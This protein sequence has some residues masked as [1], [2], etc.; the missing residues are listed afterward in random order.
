MPKKKKKSWDSIILRQQITIIVILAVSLSVLLYTVYNR[1]EN[2]IRKSNETVLR[3]KTEEVSM[4]LQNVWRNTYEIMSYLGERANV[5][6]NT[7]KMDFLLKADIYQL[8]QSNINQDECIDTLYIKDNEED[9]LILV[10]N[11]SRTYSERMQIQ[12]FV[13]ENDA[14]KH[15]TTA[16]TC[17]IVQVDGQ[18]YYSM[19]YQSGKYS[20]GA[21]SSLT[22][23][24]EKLLNDVAGTD[25]GYLMIQGDHLIYEGGYSYDS[26]LN[27]NG[28][29][30]STG[31]GDT[32]IA[33]SNLEL[34]DL[35]I[36]LI[37]KVNAI[38]KSIWSSDFMILF[39]LLTA[40]LAMDYFMRRSTIRMVSVPMGE[41]TEAYK[42]ISGG[43]INY[44]ITKETE[45]QEF[46]DFKQEFN[47]IAEEIS[48]LRI[49]EYEQKIEKQQTDLQVMRAQLRPHF[50][51][52]AITTVISMTYQ[53]RNDDIR[54]Y[55]MSL[56]K[57][58]RSMLQ[59]NLRM[60]PL[61]DELAN[62][63]DY[64]DMQKIRYPDMITTFISCDEK[65]GEV[66][67]PFLILFT[68]VENIFKHGRGGNE[69]TSVFIQCEPYEEEG[70]S[71]IRMISEDSGSG[72]SQEVLDR[73]RTGEN[74]RAMGEHIGLSN[75]YRTLQLT[76]QRT[77]LLRLSNTD[78][79][80]ARVE[81]L[82]PVKRDN[83]EN[84]DR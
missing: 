50:Y 10:I 52:N 69:E 4:M 68:A 66:E 31:N 67:V 7:G 58:M 23:Y 3:L 37:S 41:L 9:D 61:H 45:I 79:N 55:L 44:R 13:K 34:A 70:F 18:A 21:L 35:K 56:S 80:G 19:V 22:H 6:T 38:Q 62:I 51:L 53:N 72:F 25:V 81:I 73:Y 24:D 11:S 17:D 46:D 83:N 39:L 74:I 65:T 48:R 12:N 71:G 40:V 54:R 16:T 63:N 64:L 8:M 76:Y 33:S 57:F 15:N 49:E 77:D 26:L 82:I 60:V 2:E 42:Q 75:V 32:V 59:M 28:T 43:N 84:T 5:S 29:L 78:P 14:P 30:K 1:T 20:I 47:M 27:E 36:V